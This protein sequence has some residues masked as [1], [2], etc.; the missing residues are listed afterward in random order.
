MGCTLV[1]KRSSAENVENVGEV[2]VEPYANPFRVYPLVDDYHAFKKLFEEK[3]VEC[4]IINTGK[5]M[6]KD[7]PPKVTLESIEHNVE[8]DAEFKP[9]GEIEAFEYLPIDGY[10]V[11]FEDEEYVKTMIKNM[12]TRIDHLNTTLAEDEAPN[13]LPEEIAQSIQNIV[14]LLEKK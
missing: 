4:Y 7:I 10:D 5:F 8:E 11:S 6:G 12:K 3:D 2:V 1:T 9:F 13:D 14:N